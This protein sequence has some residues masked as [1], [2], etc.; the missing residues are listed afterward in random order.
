MSKVLLGKLII[1]FIIE[2]VICYHLLKWK[3]GSKVKRR[4]T[5][6]DNLKDFKEQFGEV[7]IKIT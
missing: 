7:F 5:N 6:E 4:K 3:K 1:A 2:N